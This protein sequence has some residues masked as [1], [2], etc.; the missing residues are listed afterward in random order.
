M[1]AALFA[2]GFP[3]GSDLPKTR[4][5]PKDGSFRSYF[6]SRGSSADNGYSVNLP[7]RTPDS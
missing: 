4:G 5:L 7:R 6:Y 3:R 1:A 2:F